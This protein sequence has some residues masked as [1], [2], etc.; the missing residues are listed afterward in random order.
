MSK[1]SIQNLRSSIHSKFSKIDNDIIKSDM[2]YIRH[3]RKALLFV[4]T[5]PDKLECFNKFFK[6]KYNVFLSH[7]NEIGLDILTREKIDFLICDNYELVLKAKNII[8]YTPKI[9]LINE[10]IE[11]ENIMFLNNY[12]NNIIEN[13]INNVDIESES[14][15][16]YK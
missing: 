6:N 3:G 1:I 4:C 16:I 14:I 10:K 2:D 9:I 7:T 8:N 13:L 15:K 5:D 11:E 12:D